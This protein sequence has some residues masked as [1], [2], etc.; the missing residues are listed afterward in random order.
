MTY[1]NGDVYNG[2][3]VD[4]RK[5][6]KGELVCKTGDSYIGEWFEDVP[7]GLG[8]MYFNNGLVYNGNWENGL[9]STFLFFIF[10]FSIDFNWDFLLIAASLW[11][12]DLSLW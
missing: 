3:W 12:F 1:P 11:N 4:G 2:N 7:Q 9:V 10:K 8:E 5:Q 6:G